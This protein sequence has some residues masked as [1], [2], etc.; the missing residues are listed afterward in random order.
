MK[1]ITLPILVVFML[2]SA[3]ALA[4]DLNDKVSL[5]GVLAAIGQCQ[6]LTDKAGASNECRGGIPFQPEISIRPNEVDE[7]FFRLGFAAGNGLNNVS[8]FILPPWGGDLEDDVKGIN[9][10]SRD[11][12]LIAWYS[13]T[14][15]L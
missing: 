1:Q 12:L 15:L 3:P 11:Y 7:I 9:G 14:I 10:R 5:S 13:T 4:Y 2:A 6:Q 8:P